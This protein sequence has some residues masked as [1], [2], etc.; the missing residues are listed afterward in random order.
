MD[1]FCYFYLLDFYILFMLL[2]LQVQ[3]T[4]VVVVGSLVVV[5]VGG[6]LIHERV[7]VFQTQLVGQVQ[8]NGEYVTKVPR[9]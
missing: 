6:Q 3:G 2:L 9:L 1:I 7:T 4:V 5:V 8:P